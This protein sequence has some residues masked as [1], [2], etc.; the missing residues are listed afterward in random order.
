MANLEANNDLTDTD[1]ENMQLPYIE[2]A[3]SD[4]DTVDEALEILARMNELIETQEAQSFNEKIKL[5]PNKEIA[6]IARRLTHDD[7]VE[8]IKGIAKTCLGDEDRFIKLKQEQQDERNIFLYGDGNAHEKLEEMRRNGKEGPIVMF[9]PLTQPVFE[10]VTATKGKP[11]NE[12]KRQIRK[13]MGERV[14]PEMMMYVCLGNGTDTS[15]ETIVALQTNTTPKEGDDIHDKY[16]IGDNF[17]GLLLLTNS[18]ELKAAHGK[19]SSPNPDSWRKAAEELNRELGIRGNRKQPITRLT[20]AEHHALNYGTGRMGELLRTADWLGIRFWQ[21]WLPP[22]STWR[23]DDGTIV[24]DNELEDIASTA[25]DKSFQ[26]GMVGDGRFI[27]AHSYTSDTT[28]HKFLRGELP[29]E[30]FTQSFKKDH[31]DKTPK[32]FF[33]ERDRNSQIYWDEQGLD[34]QPAIAMLWKHI[35]QR[36]EEALSRAK[37]TL[38]QI[39]KRNES[40]QKELS[41]RLRDSD[42]AKQILFAI[43][44]LRRKHSYDMDHPLI[45]RLAG[46]FASIENL[47]INM[48]NPDEMNN[49]LAGIKELIEPKNQTTKGEELNEQG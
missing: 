33:A 3:L 26:R 24:T 17:N 20:Q 14:S 43:Y 9:K 35:E 38:D 16:Y 23:L 30:E 11:P 4:V 27:R 44:K 15:P 21:K 13:Y 41:E 32:E 46:T 10:T 47:N 18:E 40:R 8:F 25:S 29:Q 7:L 42:V 45:I 36:H 49:L 1:I 22:T 37:Q 2:G 12:V 19:E 6:N 31:D 39:I 34:P 5:V 48:E 28:T